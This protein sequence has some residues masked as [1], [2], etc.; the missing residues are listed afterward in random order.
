MRRCRLTDCQVPY[1]PAYIWATGHRCALL[2]S[3]CTLAGACVRV[4]TPPAPT[5][6]S[7]K[8]SVLCFC[9]IPTS[10]PS[11]FPFMALAIVDAMKPVVPTTT[12]LPT[13]GYPPICMYL[14]LIQR[15]GQ[16][17]LAP[18]HPLQVAALCLGTCLFLC[19]CCMARR[20][21]LQSAQLAVQLL[22]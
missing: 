5:Y 15:C 3:P 19:C 22:S 9:I 4:F 1:A 12:H 14:C 16:C 7:R 2:H 11:S 18:P 17:P 8:T 13:T 21:A 10:I 20:C 6:R